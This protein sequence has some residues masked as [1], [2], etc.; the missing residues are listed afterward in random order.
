MKPTSNLGHTPSPTAHR[1]RD[2]GLTDQPPSASQPL[3]QR[4]GTSEPGGALATPRPAAPAGQPRAA[5]EPLPQGSEHSVATVHHSNARPRAQ[6]FDDVVQ[7]RH[8]QSSAP[9]RHHSGDSEMP[10]R[11]AAHLEPPRRVRR[12][13]PEPQ[14]VAQPTQPAAPAA[15]RWADNAEARATPASRAGLPSMP[16]RKPDREDDDKPV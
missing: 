1:G 8:F 9:T 16:M 5:A 2:T 10:L 12:A 13:P 15:S 3:R 7:V 11:N 14:P 6:T 4:L